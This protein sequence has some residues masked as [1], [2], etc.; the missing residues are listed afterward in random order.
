MRAALVLLVALAALAVAPAADAHHCK[1]GHKNRPGCQPPPPT[2]TVLFDEQFNGPA[3]AAPDP[4]ALVAQGLLLGRL[5][6]RRR[7]RGFVRPAVQR[8]FERAGPAALTARYQPGFRDR[9]GQGPWDYTGAKVESAKDWTSPVT[10]LFCLT[11]G[12]MDAWIKQPNEEAGT[13]SGFWTKGVPTA[14]REFAEVDVVEYLSNDPDGT[15]HAHVHQ[16]DLDVGRTG[17]GGRACDAGVDL[18]AGFHKYSAAWSPGRV[19]ILLDDRLCFSALRA[20][21]ATWYGDGNPAYLLLSNGVGDWLSAGP[22]PS[23]FPASMLVDRV[24]VTR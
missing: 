23:Q 8:G 6:G 20:N 17:T 7:A 18:G 4:G 2:G 21:Y 22:N 14:G 10:C 24:L 1:G 16:W 11:Y 12:R 3:G 19:D 5:P 9:Y 13:W 15:W